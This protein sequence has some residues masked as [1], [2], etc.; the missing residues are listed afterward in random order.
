MRSIRSG[1]SIAVCLLTALLLT[2]RP[3]PVAGQ[4]RDQDAYNRAFATLS[5]YLNRA[6][7]QFD[8]DTYSFV[9]GNF[10]DTALGCPYVA[11]SVTPT[12]IAAYQFTFVVDGMSYD[13]RVAPDALVAF[14]C[15]P[16]QTIATPVPT[17]GAT[18][19]PTL[20]GATVPPGITLT[21]IP[22]IAPVEL[23]QVTPTPCPADFAGFLPS[24]LRVGIGASVTRA[25][26]AGN[27]LRV[28]PSIDGL[29]VGLIT[30]NTTADVIGGPSCDLVSRLV[31]WQV[32]YNGVIG[33]TAEGAL[34]DDYY[35]DPA[36]ATGQ[37][38]PLTP[39]TAANAAPG[40]AI[41]LPAERTLPEELSAITT[42]TATTLRP[43]AGIEDTASDLTFA[44]T[45]QPNNGRITLGTGAGIASYTLPDLQADLPASFAVENLTA[46]QYV[47]GDILLYGTG[48]GEIG[49]LLLGDDPVALDTLRVDET[50]NAIAGAQVQPPPERRDPANPDA[51]E[52]R[53]AVGSGALYGGEGEEQISLFTFSSE[54][55]LLT[56]LQA[57]AD[58]YVRGVAISHDGRFVAYTDTA[59]RILNF[60]TGDELL[61]L[62]TD[63]LAAPF[64]W[65]SPQEFDPATPI[66]LEDTRFAYD[67][68]GE[69]TVRSLAEDGDASAVTMTDPTSDA[70][71]AQ[72]IDLVFS[73]GGDLLIALYAESFGETGDP[74]PPAAR[75]VVYDAATGDAL[76]EAT[77]R[78]GSSVAINDSAT[79]MAVTQLE[80]VVL[81][82][83]P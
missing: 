83:V 44:A 57:D 7:T 14:V 31:W 61:E 71:A 54:G 60:D 6:L 66:P 24:R 48:A 11:G 43:L 12:P 32:S 36:S 1:I 22:T 63:N 58:F 5:E 56:S 26:L 47:G 59:T 2:H 8:I 64:A 38:I 28:T 39:T 20:P 37:P 33:W 35:L 41:G 73:P 70:A 78:N 52:V 27:R 13:V 9:I 68:G 77:L 55:D 16:P 23:V 67:N 21:P 72:A 34:P 40:N 30:P 29:Q 42:A 18:S 4:T 51:F 82:G 76:Y 3:L 74:Q 49:G 79:L 17:G 46:V 65:L 10:G 50:V 62:A 25:A 15:A 81:F 19:V 80:G 45:F 69:I 75:L 53:V